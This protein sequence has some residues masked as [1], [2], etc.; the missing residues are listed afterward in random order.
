VID[1][2]DVEDEETSVLAEVIETLTGDSVNA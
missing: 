1:V 2:G